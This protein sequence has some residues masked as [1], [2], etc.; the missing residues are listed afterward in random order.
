MKFKCKTSNIT[1]DKISDA[2][3]DY[4]IGKYCSDC[5]LLHFCCK[6]D[7]T[8]NDEKE[9]IKL[10]GI[11][12]IE[13]EKP[14]EEWTLKEIKEE[15]ESHRKDK[16][17]YNCKFLNS[18]ICGGYVYGWN[19][20]EQKKFTKEEISAA[21]AIVELYKN[22]NEI[23][24]EKGLYCN[25]YSTHTKQFLMSIP[26]YKFPSI[27]EGETVLIKDILEEQNG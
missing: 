6:E 16:S 13:E 15:C 26:R 27:K 17:C 14:L 21:K 25:V 7:R 12:I 19:I 18:T 9:I 8:D 4:C 11:E 3:H 2:I 1:Y 23:Y 10:I 20:N 5:V 22:A 24:F